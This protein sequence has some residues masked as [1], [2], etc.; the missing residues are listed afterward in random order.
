LFVVNWM[1]T[2]LSDAYKITGAFTNVQMTI[3]IFSI[4]YFINK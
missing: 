4:V 1:N 2:A 3:E